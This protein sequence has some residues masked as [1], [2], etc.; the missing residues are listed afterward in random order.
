M[1]GTSDDAIGQVDAA[2]ILHPACDIILSMRVPVLSRAD[3]AIG[4][5]AVSVITD[6]WGAWMVVRKTRRSRRAV[7][8]ALLVLT[9]GLVSGCGSGGSG[10]PARTGGT[11][12][13]GSSSAASTSRTTSEDPRTA[14]ASRAAVA[15]YQGYVQ[16]FAAAAQIPDPE[17]PALS[18]YAADPLLSLTRHNVR[19][20]KTNGQVQLGA[21][22]VTVKSTTVDLAHKPPVV[23]IHACLDYSTLRLV[24][25][26]NHS[27]VPNSQIT[28]AKVSAIVTAWQYVNGQWLVNEAKDG[29]DPC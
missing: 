4:A 17:Y 5:A 27:P 2:K 7:A 16:A 20:L 21:Q 28:T 15:A 11:T 24:Y 1:A 12:G 14:D 9:L 19:V 18:R 23:T 29:A 6:P 3:A 22:S 10:G 13:S 8:S 26:A 25:T